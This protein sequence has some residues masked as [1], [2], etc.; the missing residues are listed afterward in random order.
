MSV[1]Q[2][3]EGD[4]GGNEIP[5]A[6][7]RNLH[8]LWDN[9][10]G[11]AYYLR[12]V[13]R[14]VVELSDRKRY[15]DVWDSAAKETSVRK[16]IDESHELAKSVVYSEAILN[17]VRN[18]PAGERLG[19][20]ELSDDYMRVAGDAARRRVIAAGIRLGVLLG[21]EGDGARSGRQIAMGQG[22]DILHLFPYFK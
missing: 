10:L 1:R 8:S 16:W 5:L 7:G 3:P 12:D 18:T 2:F 22:I 4:R 11:R 14:M 17:A 13:D 21:G 9:L 19:P 6:R 15:G 20:I